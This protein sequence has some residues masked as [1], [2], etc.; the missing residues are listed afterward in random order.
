MSDTKQPLDLSALEADYDIIGELNAPGA[1]HTYI[2]SRRQQDAKRRADDA[3]VL[4]SVVSTPAGDEG[5]ALSHLAAD[6]QLLAR[7]RHRRLVPVVEGRWLGKDAFA[8]V[9]QRTN[10]S[11]LAEKLVTGEAFSTP[12]I[13][14]ILREVNGLIEWAREQKVV[15]RHVDA[16]HVYLEPRTDRVRVSFSVAPIPRIHHADAADDARTIA[17]LALA[18]LTGNETERDVSGESLLELRPDLPEQL[19]TATSALLDE[20]ST[21][22]SEDVASYLALIA[23]AAPLAAGETEAERIR[24]IILEEQIVER[25]KLANERAAFEQA[26]ADERAA[27]AEEHARFEQMMADEREKFAR[28]MEEERERFAAEKA[29]LQRVVL[30][31][32]ASLVDRRAELERAVEAQRARLE[33]AALRDRQQIERL[34]AELIAAGEREVEK[35]RETALEDIVDET[36][37]T[38]ERYAAPVFMPPKV[39]PLE[40]LVFDDDSVLM[41]EQGSDAGVPSSDAAS[42]AA[43]SEPTR[44][45]GRTSRKRRLVSAGIAAAVIIVAA[46]AIALGSR[47]GPR[48]V[49]TPVSRPVVGPVAAMPLPA[50]PLP[51]VPLPT[52]ADVVDSTKRSLVRPLDDSARAAAR[53]RRLMRERALRDTS[54]ASDSTLRAHSDGALRRDSTSRDSTVKRDTTPRRDTIPAR[55][56]AARRGVN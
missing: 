27:R 41:R 11:S 49:A 14:A 54:S 12:R 42:V 10:D 28:A 35:K 22:T 15:H 9:T 1:A 3:R 47:R 53:A 39:A 29:K 36:T 55:Q 45:L 23:M 16:E 17:R 34:R 5:N 32:R 21:S 48:P 33:Q 52:A 4:I 38:D 19:A 6:T 13:A 24:L 51:A 44:I 20:K 40:A 30:D 25:E 8:V 46:S 7:L 26:M 56:P 31:E 37:L 18:M 2:A 43:S 50:V